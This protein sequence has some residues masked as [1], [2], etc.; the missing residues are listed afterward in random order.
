MSWSISM[1]RVES[2]ARM[3]LSSRIKF[4]WGL[5]ELNFFRAFNWCPLK[6]V[7]GILYLGNSYLGM[8]LLILGCYR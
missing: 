6:S 5:S 8:N 2:G 1:L 3:S 7:L 4:N